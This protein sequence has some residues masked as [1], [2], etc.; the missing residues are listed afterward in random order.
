MDCQAYF[1]K[2]KKKKVLN[3]KPETHPFLTKPIKDGGAGY[4]STYKAVTGKEPY[5]TS[6]KMRKSPNKCQI[7][8]YTIDFIFQTPGVQGTS[9][10]LPPEQRQFDPILDTLLPDSRCGSDHISLIADIV[11]EDTS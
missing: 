10:L 1:D 8:K 6:W 11:S 3:Y 4:Q 2:E 9:V 7:F 5:V